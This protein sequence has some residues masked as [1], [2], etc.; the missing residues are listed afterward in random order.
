MRIQTL[1]IWANDLKESVRRKTFVFD[2]APR[3][4]CDVHTSQQM[5]VFGRTVLAQG[6]SILTVIPLPEDTWGW[7]RSIR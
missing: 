5:E 4:P 1:R 6:K 7:R 3:P 2:L